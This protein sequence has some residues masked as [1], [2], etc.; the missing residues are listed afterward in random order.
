MIFWAKE[1]FET[2]YFINYVT[3]VGQILFL[4]SNISNFHNVR[5]QRVTL[6]KMRIEKRLTL[7]YANYSQCTE[8]SRGSIP[9]HYVRP[10]RFTSTFWNCVM[11][12]SSS[13]LLVFQKIPFPNNLTFQLS[14]N[15][16][17]ISVFSTAT[18]INLQQNYS[19]EN[20]FLSKNLYNWELTEGKSSLEH[21]LNQNYIWF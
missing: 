21:N 12:W 2:L 5:L 16:A 14:F 17:N 3:T 11:Y 20:I 10:P 6:A 9:K 4:G 13:L 15:S 1:Y 8:R 19:P 7:Q 18:D